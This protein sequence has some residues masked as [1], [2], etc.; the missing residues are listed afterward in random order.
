MNSRDE[1]KE[2]EPIQNFDVNSNLDNFKIEPIK[3][4]ESLML[5]ALNSN[6][7]VEENFIKDLEKI[8]NVTSN[9]KFKKKKTDNIEF[10]H[11]N[12]IDAKLKEDTSNNSKLNIE[13]NN[14]FNNSFNNNSKLRL[15][16]IHNNSEIV[17]SCKL[18][19]PEIC[20]QEDINK[21]DFNINE[22]SIKPENH[23]IVFNQKINNVIDDIKENNIIDEKKIEEL[24]ISIKNNKDGEEIK[25]D[26]EN[27]IKEKK[28]SL[29]L[30]Y[31]VEQEKLE[32]NSDLFEKKKIYTDIE[33]D[34]IFLNKDVF[35]NLEKRIENKIEMT[36][37]IE[38]I[39]QNNLISNENQFNEEEN[40]AFIEKKILNEKE[41]NNKFNSTIKNISLKKKRTSCQNVYKYILK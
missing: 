40:Q 30:N 23:I 7:F 12:E 28:D 39:I 35:D 17:D 9:L 37:K 6:K 24:K 25:H 38:L 15:K 16:N 2:I 32:I 26:S 11:N 5:T 1:K 21:K 31:N 34:N 3:A 29:I 36:E 20:N 8:E 33:K 27:S 18:L 14:N 19:K 41:N 13:E 10:N 22:N 4:K